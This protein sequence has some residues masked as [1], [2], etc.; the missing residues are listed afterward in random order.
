MAT[1]F[2]SFVTPEETPSFGLMTEQGVWDLRKRGA[3][4][5]LAD[6]IERGL[7]AG[8]A[9]LDDQPDHACDAIRLLPVIPDPKRIIC[10]GLNYHDHVAE[11]ER[12]D[13]DKP[14]IFLR[15][16]SS[17]V[18]HGQSIIHP[19][20]TSRL[21]YEGELAVIIGKGGRR[22]ARDQALGHVA[23]YA[24]YNDVTAR[25]WQ[26]HST[27]WAPGKNFPATGA[28]GPWMIPAADL[29]ERSRCSLVTRLN[30][31]EVQRALLT[32]MIFSIEDL[33]EYVSI[34]TPLDAGDVIVSGTP[35]G[36][37]DRRDPP[38]YLREGDEVSVEITGI[39]TLRNRV[40]KE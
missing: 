19:P 12:P 1:R 17:Q 29:P 34:F 33:I 11:M 8:A 5:T 35:G 15:L 31:E 30:G 2:V 25:D 26:R 37:G 18:S 28:F 21:D 16:P 24:C 38:R 32:Q 6:F 22:I 7:G 27:Q 14:T 9:I 4:E 3:G 40:A 23:G 20:E 39:G 10:V 36:V 13:S